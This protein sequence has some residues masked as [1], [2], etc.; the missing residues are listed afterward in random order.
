[1]SVRAALALVVLV[2]ACQ[3]QARRPITI[4]NHAIDDGGGYPNE[5]ITEESVVRFLSWRFKRQL[6][7]GT[8]E[9]TYN[10]TQADLI[11]ELHTMGIRTIDDLAAIVPEDFETRGAG[12]F[13]TSDPANIP[14]IVRDFMMIHDADR[15]FQHAWK[16][17]WQSILPEN[18]SALRGYVTD[19]SPFYDAGVL[20]Q[21]QV[22]GAQDVA[23]DSP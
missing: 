22:S 17:R 7:A 9:A 1:V 21:D 19:F 18:V 15:Y 10:D 13:V 12:E 5:P 6:D 2:A 23:R 20:T 8:F 3:P 16:S 4:E 14:G 11:D